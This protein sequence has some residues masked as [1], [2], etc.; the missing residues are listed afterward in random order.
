MT[1]T[2]RGTVRVAAPAAVSEEMTPV[3]LPRRFDYLRRTSRSTTRVIV[4]VDG[5]GHAEWSEQA[6]GEVR[7]F[8]VVPSASERKAVLD[9][10]RKGKTTSLT[11]VEP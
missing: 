6:P 3:V 7:W 1:V 10:L 11:V 9:W 5:R 8:P 4:D 2:T